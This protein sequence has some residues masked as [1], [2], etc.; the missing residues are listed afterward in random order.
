MEARLSLVT[1]A[2]A[3]VARARRFYGEG[4][5]WR[6]SSAGDASICFVQLGGIGLALF[7]RSAFAAEIGTADAGAGRPGI[8]L[9]HNVR[10]AA[11][12]ARVLAEAE[13]AGGRIV[14]PA[15][16]ADW[17]GTSGYFTDPDGHYWEVAHN[18]FFAMAD[19]G[20]VTLP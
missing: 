12:V 7:E 9:A 17:G 2:V 14:K 10:E 1:L 3:D 4:L 18:P 8:V 19:D 11:D 13:A 16:K 6:V 5:G 15:A 20:A